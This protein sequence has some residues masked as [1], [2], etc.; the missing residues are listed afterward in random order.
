[1]N[2]FTGTFS[3]FQ[4]RKPVKMKRNTRKQNSYNRIILQIMLQVCNPTAPGT[5]P[6]GYDCSSSTLATQYVC[7]LRPFMLTPSSC[8]S[9]YILCIYLYLYAINVQ[10]SLVVS[11]NTMLQ[12]CAKIYIKTIA[13]NEITLTIVVIVIPSLLHHNHNINV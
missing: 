13:N 12:I 11:S 4:K 1:M 8:Q 3:H 5:C 6:S 7:C 10:L 2:T 9:G